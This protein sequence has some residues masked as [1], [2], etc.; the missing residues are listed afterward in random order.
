MGAE[1]NLLTGDPDRRTMVN[2]EGKVA[3]EGKRNPLHRFVLSKSDKDK[4]S[5]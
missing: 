3:K 2:I 5:A 1:I 4:I